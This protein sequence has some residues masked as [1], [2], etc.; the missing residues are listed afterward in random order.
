MAI[1]TDLDPRIERTHRLVL[2]A[3]AELLGECGFGRTSIEAISERS[4]V[5]RS[6]IY[7]H[8]PDR[9]E[10][11]LESIGK[12]VEMTRATDTGDLRADLI[13]LYSHLGEMLNDEATRSMVASFVAEATRDPELAALN[14]KFI[15]ARR[16]ATSELIKNAVERGD[17]PT[18]TDPDQMAHDLAGG[19]FFRGLVL[20]Q[21]T[22][23]TWIATHVDR[24]ISICSEG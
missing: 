15:E 24:W 9:T 13:R 5:A 3:T 21:P 11:L 12:R 8:W 23:E 4:G 22:D 18:E 1:P 17:L 10:L 19:I 6:T 20:R 14:S 2:E 16:Q 7:R